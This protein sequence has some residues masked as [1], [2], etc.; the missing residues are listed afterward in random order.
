MTIPKRLFITLKNYAIDFQETAI[1]FDNI[2][3][4]K[5]LKATTS[6]TTPLISC[7][8]AADFSKPFKIAVHAPTAQIIS[9]FLH[10]P[11]SGMAIQGLLSFTG[12]YF[13]TYYEIP[14]DFNLWKELDFIWKHPRWI[15]EHI[16]KIP[17][18]NGN[19]EENPANNKI[20]TDFTNIGGLMMVGFGNEAKIIK[21]PDEKNGDN[22]AGTIIQPE[23]D[24]DSEFFNASGTKRGFEKSDNE[25]DQLMSSPKQDI[26]RSSI[27]VAGSENFEACGDPE[28]FARLY[29]TNIVDT[30]GY[31]D[32]ESDDRA[33]LIPT[34]KEN[35][36]AVVEV[37]YATDRRRSP[38][39]ETVGYL[40]KRGPLSY[41]TCQVNI[42]KHRKQGEIPRPAWWKLE[43]KERPEKHLMILENSLLSENLFFDRLAAQIDKANEHDTFVFIHGYNVSFED[44]IR[45]SAQMAYDLNFEGAPIVYSWP[46]NA[47]AS[48]YLGD[49]D[50]VR[51]TVTNIIQ[52]LRD[53]K[54]KTQAKKI[55]LIAHSMGNRALT[56]A[57]VALRQDSFFHEFCFNQI[58]LAAPDIDAEI[59]VRDIVPKL[60][61]S[62]SR[63]TLYTS[64]NDLALQ[65][66]R[67]LR[68]N[69]IA[70]AGQSGIRI[71]YCNGMDTIDASDVKADLLGHGYFASTAPLINDIYLLTKHNHPPED[72]NLLKMVAEHG[73]Y[74]KFRK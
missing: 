49:E 31:G 19:Y 22:G 36:N 18:L 38:R 67:K 20:P 56:D 74:W 27:S 1:L 25:S 63:L 4:V 16:K 24:S 73:V 32:L 40:N 59:F 61:T 62:A 43:F 66:S 8:I 12:Q 30:P 55:H 7:Q 65:S 33:R 53:V 35:E 44:S 60:L 29:K 41:G 26:E 70:R 64:A 48:S 71:V 9:I 51:F 15:S 68:G 72:R 2:S 10:D 57:L 6:E 69:R 37:F 28:E 46:S 13:Q 42:P 17:F 34:V 54:E 5:F 50:N 58:I 21:K 11:A 23:I 52:F 3:L 14:V 39:R 45:R 47:T